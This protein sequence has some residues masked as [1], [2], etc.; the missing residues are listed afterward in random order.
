MAQI[1]RRRTQQTRHGV[2][3]LIL[4]HIELEQGLLAAEPALRQRLCQRSL[5]DTGRPEE[6]HRTDRP[7]RLP[8]SGA[9]APDSPGHGGDSPALAHDFGVQALFEAGQTFPLLFA[10]PLSWHAAGLRHHPGNFLPAED[11]VF[12]PFPLGPDAHCRAGFVHEVD[13]LIRQTAPRQIPH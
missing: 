7:A 1:A 10:H 5:T 11:G 13:G 2:L 12:L 3:L 6:E 8:Q 9:A 4:R